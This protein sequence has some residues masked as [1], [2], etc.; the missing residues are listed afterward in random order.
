MTIITCRVELRACVKMTDESG[1]DRWKHSSLFSLH[2]HTK[3]LLNPSDHLINCTCKLVLCF[4]VVC[5][6]IIKKKTHQA[7]TLKLVQQTPFSSKQLLTLFDSY[8]KRKITT[9]FAFFPSQ[10]SA[11]LLWFNEKAFGCLLSNFRTLRLL[12]FHFFCFG[13]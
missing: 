2:I 13:H 7:G 8:P 9:F 1:C 10:H 6:I 11:V 4:P 5:L 12:H 3:W